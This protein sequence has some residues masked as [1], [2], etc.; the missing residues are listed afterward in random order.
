MTVSVV[1]PCRDEERNIRECIEAIYA[2]ELSGG[3]DIEVLVIDGMSTD[4]TPQ[5]VEKLQSQY[6]N[7]RLI[8]NALRVTPV[9]FN[10]G[11]RE[12]RGEYIQLV[13]ARHIISRD[14][15]KEAR[16]ILENDPRIWCV[17]GRVVNVYQNEE[18]EIIGLAMASSFG[19]GVGN[20]RVLQRSGYVDTVGTPMYRRSVFDQIGLFNEVLIRNQDD[21][22]N[23]RI[24]ANGG[25]IYLNTDVR[26]RYYVRAK[27]SNLFT[28]YFQY[29]YWKV[30]VNKLHNT[31]TSARQLVPLC[32]VLGLF[33]GFLLSLF[34]PFVTWTYLLGIAFYALMSVVF[35]VSSAESLGKGLRVAT[36]FP[37]L[38]V[39][40]GWGYLKGIIDFVF[41]NRRPASAAVRLSR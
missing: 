8:P 32:F 20:F 39:A 24:T 27:V 22:L 6:P 35:G 25:R 36:I 13:G 23:Y 18:S 37:V 41:L 10:I 15:L 34:V 3:D 40:Y 12:S 19:V 21:E 17:G 7:L 14:Y 1:I 11:I 9:A 29:G 2:S 30:Y 33:I 5:E 4:G 26:I 28:Q 38:H 16:R 31:V